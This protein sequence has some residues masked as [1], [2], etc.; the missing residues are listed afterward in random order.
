M[1]KGGEKI[2]GLVA[3][4]TKKVAFTANSTVSSVY[5]HQPKVPNKIKLLKNKNIIL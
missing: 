5:V 2:L 4:M 1:I 3:D